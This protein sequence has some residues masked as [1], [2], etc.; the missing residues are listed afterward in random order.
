MLLWKWS[1]RERKWKSLK[2]ETAYIG[3]GSN[4]GDR[5][6]YVKDAIEMLSATDGIT[7][8]VV[9]PLYETKPV[10]FTEQPNFLN[11]VV[12]IS[13]SLSPYQ[14]LDVCMLI[15]S[16]LQRARTIKWG[17]RTVDLDILFYGNLVM[18]EDRLTIPHHLLHERGFVLLPM[19]EI[20]PEFIHPKLNISIKA[21]CER[22][23]DCV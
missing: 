12:E 23:G 8:N 18:A 6:K 10:G 9:S 19:R 20:A 5:E 1:I 17:P 15:E 4:L 7:I 21:L 16:E 22:L 2:V 14:L 13:T 3:L 11:C